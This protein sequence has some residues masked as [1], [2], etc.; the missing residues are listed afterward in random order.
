M[1][2]VMQAVAEWDMIQEGDRLLLGLSGGKDSLCL[3]HALHEIQRRAPINFE[4]ACATVDPGTVAFNPRP[5]IAYCA[6]LGVKY[7]YLEDPIFERA[8]SGSLRGS[9]I[10]SFCARMKRGLLYSCVRKEGYNKLVLAQH[11][12]DMAESWMMSAFHNGTS[13]TMSFIYRYI[14][15]E[16]C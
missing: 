15:N 8:S 6:A 10:C 12:D 16:S 3:L 4:I 2:R 9:S 11:L 7:F 13:R 14:L 5:L 1:K